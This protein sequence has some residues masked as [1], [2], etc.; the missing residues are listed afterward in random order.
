MSY[1][2]DWESRRRLVF[3]SDEY[4][5]RH[6]GAK[7]G[8]FGA[9]NLECH[10]IVPKRMDGSDHPR[11]LITLCE[12]CHTELHRVQ[13][14]DRVCSHSTWD[15]IISGSASDVIGRP[16]L[17]CLTRVSDFA[18]AG[19]VVAMLGGIMSIALDGVSLTSTVAATWRV[20]TV[21]GQERFRLLPWIAGLLGLRYLQFL[22]NVVRST[23]GFNTVI[24]FGGWKP[25][26]WVATAVL[27]CAWAL[28][29]WGDAV[30][31]RTTVEKGVLPRSIYALCLLTATLTVTGTYL[32]GRRD[33]VSD[34]WLWYRVALLH[35][36]V[37]LGAT[38]VGTGPV[39]G[40]GPVFAVTAPVCAC[41]VLAALITEVRGESPGLKGGDES[42][43]R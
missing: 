42:D 6:C 5:C 30:W 22:A 32:F 43:K 13:E 2:G 7:G 33:G 15:A 20:G 18:L 40:G 36:T 41:T 21:V 23:E 9:A 25:Y 4:Q 26:V 14:S 28:V 34:T 39:S 11:N 16:V 38:A 8:R 17:A 29:L 12:V 24:P 31:W 37:V 3:L 35:F 19:L 10:H 27:V 1:P